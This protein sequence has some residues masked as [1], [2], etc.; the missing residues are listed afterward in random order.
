MLLEFEFKNISE[1][2]ITNELVGQVRAIFDAKYN[3]FSINE[4]IYCIM[5]F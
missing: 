5:N 4:N 3:K 1:K 2:K